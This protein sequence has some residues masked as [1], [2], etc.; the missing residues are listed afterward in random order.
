MEPKLVQH[1][2]R[3]SGFLPLHD[4]CSNRSLDEEIAIN[5]MKILVAKY[6]KLLKKSV[7]EDLG[8]ASWTIS[9]DLNQPP[10]DLAKE[11]MSVGF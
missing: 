2:N 10:I 4:L 7:G 5:I 8:E 3:L 1:M 9:A 11:S 6:P